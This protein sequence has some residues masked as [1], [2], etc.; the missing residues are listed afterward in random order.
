MASGSSPLARG[1]HV[2]VRVE[3]T[4]LGIIP[5]RAGFTTACSNGAPGP[6]DHPRSRGVY[7][8]PLTRLISR[9]GSSPL[10]RGL[11]RVG[12]ASSAAGRIIPA[13]AGFTG[14]G[15]AAVPDSADHPRSRG[16]YMS[17]VVAGASVPGSS[18]LAR[19]LLVPVPGVYDVSGI[20]PARAGFT[21]SGPRP[22]SSWRDHPRSRGV[23]NS[24]ADDVPYGMG[25]SRSRGVYFLS[26]WGAFLAP[27]SSPLARGL[28]LR[29]RR[30]PLR[31]GIIPARA[32]F[33]S[34]TEVRLVRLPDHPRSRGVYGRLLCGVWAEG[35]SSPLARGLQSG[36]VSEWDLEGI[37]PA[38]AGFTATAAGEVRIF[39]DHPRSRG[40]YGRL[41]C[42]VWAEG[43]SSPLA[44][45][46]RRRPSVPQVWAGIIPARA[47]FTRPCLRTRPRLRDHPRSRGVYD[48]AWDDEAWEAGSSPLA[49][50]L[51]GNSKSSPA[52]WRIIPAR[53][54]FTTTNVR[55]RTQRPDHPRSRGVYRAVVISR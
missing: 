29:C 43:G 4:L 20:I 36:W 19:G 10:A 8:P 35:G 11:Q 45:G 28:Q 21:A 39:E 48:R 37:I 33:T 6:E 51:P 26:A 40:V 32:G 49:R 30:R 12:C 1:L 41:L 50:G 13:R 9:L 55:I 3:P 31:Y 47:G 17:P 53:A 27:G 34:R 54:G 24:A 42:G 16:V 7:L 46:L 52:P 22:P 15:A 25:S 14:P 38:R 44:R 23:Y 2:G 5:A 18:P